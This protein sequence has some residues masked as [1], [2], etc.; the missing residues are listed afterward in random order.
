MLRI[1]IPVKGGLVHSVALWIFEE[2]NAAVR[3][4]VYSNFDGRIKSLSSSSRVPSSPSVLRSDPLKRVPCHDVGSVSSRAFHPVRCVHV[5]TRLPATRGNLRTLTS[6]AVLAVFR[7]ATMRFT[8]RDGDLA[9]TAFLQLGGWAWKETGV[10][11]VKVVV[12]RYQISKFFERTKL[13]S[14][15]WQECAGTANPEAGVRPWVAKVTDSDGTDDG[16][17]VELAR[18]AML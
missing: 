15:S 1:E 5:S 2:N 8:H 16:D 18:F 10:V 13:N 9:R 17:T 7:I 4:T 3:G 14:R 6:I 12:G 11:V